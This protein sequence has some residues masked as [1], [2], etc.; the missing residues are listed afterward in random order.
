YPH[1]ETAGTA[2]SCKY[3][4]RIGIALC[5]KR[6]GHGDEIREGVAFVEQS[7]FG[8]RSPFSRPPRTWAMAWMKPRSKRLATDGVKVDCMA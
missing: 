8:Q 7:T 2:T 4:L 1:K 5:D 6:L 3:R